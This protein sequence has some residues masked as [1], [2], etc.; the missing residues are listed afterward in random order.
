MP[1]AAVPPHAWYMVLFSAGMIVVGW[2]MVGRI[3]GI[4]ASG[5]SALLLLPADSLLSE[6]G[7]REA[8]VVSTALFI[9]SVMSIVAH[10]VALAVRHSAKGSVPPI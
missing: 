8:G 3:A 7:G 1:L 10:I 5:V 2:M 6:T 4:V 9:V